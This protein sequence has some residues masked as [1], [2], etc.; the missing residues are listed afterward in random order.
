MAGASDV[1][2]TIKS[3]YDGVNSLIGGGQG[4][5]EGLKE[6]LSFKRKCAWYPALRGADALIRDGEFASFKK[7]VCEA[8]CRMEPAFQWGVCQRLGE[9]AANSKWDI[10]TRRSAVA[11]LGEMYC[12]DEDWGQDVGVKEWILDILKRLSSPSVGTVQFAEGLLQELESKATSQQRIVIQT[13]RQKNTIS[14][15]LRVVVPSLVPTTL[16][17]RVQSKPAVEGSLRQLRKQRL[18][19]RGNAVYIRPQAKVGLQASDDQRFPLME[20]VE[21]FLQSNQKVFLLLGDSGAG[22]STFNRQLEYELWN[23]YKKNTGRIP[24]FINLPAIDKPEQD[25][26]AKHLR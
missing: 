12:N 21:E 15:P 9:I 8:P 18:K 6:G 25:M 11:F 7:L 24:L 23:S 5:I 17:D 19:E 10:L 3:A 1:Y 2:Q 4:F 13:Y 14:Y 22:K 26:I 16:L 20:K